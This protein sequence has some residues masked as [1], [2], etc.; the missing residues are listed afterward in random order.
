MRTPDGRECRHYYVD[1]HR[2]REGKETCRLL[3]GTPDAER[4]TSD[5]CRTCPVPEIRRANT[6]PEMQLH[7]RIQRRPLRFWEGPRVHVRATCEKGGGPV[8]D[9]YVGCGLCHEPLNFVV[10][11]E[12][13]DTTD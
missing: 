7:A 9:P 11:D 5:L 2:W 8:E 6:C 12:E 10:A 1:T 13:S 3:E 4:W